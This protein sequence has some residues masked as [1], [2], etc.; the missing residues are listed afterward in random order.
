M[1]TDYGM[2]ENIGYIGFKDS[3]QGQKSFS[4]ETNTKIDEEV[5]II[6]D[7]AKTKTMSVLK[8]KETFLRDLSENLLEKETLDLK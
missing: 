3:S 8:E 2:S 7:E 1:V 4:S 5:K 6:L